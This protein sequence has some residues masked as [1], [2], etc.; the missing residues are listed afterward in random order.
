[1]AGRS[2]ILVLFFLITIGCKNPDTVA[3]EIAKIK[4]DL[5]VSRFDRDFA[6]A[7]SDNLGQL[8]NKY[9]YL[10]PVQY[11]DS[12]WIEKMQD[13]VQKELL[14]EVDR[15]F[16][17]FEAERADM[18]L[19]FKHIVHYFPQTMVPEVV[20]VISDV[21][22]NNRIILADSLLLIGLDNYL[23][24][25][26]RFYRGMSRYVAKDLDKKYLNSDIAS[27]YANEKI[28]Q[29]SD[30]SF[31]SQ[32]IFYG[33]VL[34]LKDIWMPLSDDTLKIHYTQEE[35]DW[36]E[37]NEEQMWRYF[38]ERE[39][40]YSTDQGLAPRFLDPAPFSKFRLEL[41][42]ESP[43]RAGRYIGWMIVRSFMEKNKV[44]LN[45]MLMLPADEL[46]RKSAYK[47]KN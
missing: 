25:E 39:Y 41:D 2:L 13:T 28:G 40:L 45:E 44:G 12:V 34:Y 31:L 19:L 37:A 9:P 38:I 46:F 1:M 7:G 29:P 35:L 21:D 22:Y 24:P 4:L 47:P 16:G 17:D 11:T 10:F 8:K 6:S 3:E 32:M 5:K 23:G 26:H 14:E 30:R 20:T 27:V 43:G 15:T 33:K 36:A 42:S 18:E